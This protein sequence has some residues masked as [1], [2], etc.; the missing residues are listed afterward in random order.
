MA[1][2]RA[3][4]T[5]Q[6]LQTSGNAKDD[7]G[8]SYASTVRESVADA[9]C[10]GR[11]KCAVCRSHVQE[12]SCHPRSGVSCR[13]FLRMPRPLTDTY[14]YVQRMKRQQIE[15]RQHAVGRAILPT[16][17]TMKRLR[18]SRCQPRYPAKRRHRGAHRIGSRLLSMLS[19]EFLPNCHGASFLLEAAAV[20]MIIKTR[21][22]V[23]TIHRV[24]PNGII[25][26][27]ERSACQA[28]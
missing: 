3:G 7:S 12:R 22:G 28:H 16:Q 24:W 17:D 9:Q 20:S 2:Y 18:A 26:S 19:I 25:L 23:S 5:R 8:T 21:A 13:A 1:R 6:V 27:M 4:I 11:D 15:A 10:A 14:F